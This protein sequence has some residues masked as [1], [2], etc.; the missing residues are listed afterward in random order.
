L[1]LR[2]ASIPS[3]YDDGLYDRYHFFAPNTITRYL[4]RLDVG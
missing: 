3:S 4:R 1:K 2:R